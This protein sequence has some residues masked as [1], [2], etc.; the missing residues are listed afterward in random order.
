MQFTNSIRAFA[1]TAGGR[2]QADLIVNKHGASNDE[3][4]RRGGR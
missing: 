1:V 3:Y 4:R 2:P